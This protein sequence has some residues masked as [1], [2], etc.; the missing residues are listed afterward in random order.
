M[1]NKSNNTGSI[2]DAIAGDILVYDGHVEIVA[3]PTNGDRFIVYNCGYTSHIRS[4]KYGGFPE[5][6]KSGHTKSTILKIIN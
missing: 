3:A 1:Y 4:E 2:D 6:S 5:A